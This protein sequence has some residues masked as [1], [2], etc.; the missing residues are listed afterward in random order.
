LPHW[1][2]NSPLLLT[3]LVI[4]AG[5][6]GAARPAPLPPGRVQFVEAGTAQGDI[7]GSGTIVWQNPAGRGVTLPV[8]AT[9]PVVIAATSA[10]SVTA[11]GA[12]AGARYWER[13]VGGSIAGPPT[14][15]GHRIYVG[16]RARDGSVYAIDPVSGRRIWSRRVGDVRGGVVF[17]DRLVLAGTAR[18]ELV[19]LD[20][21]AGVIRWRTQ[22]AGAVATTPVVRGTHAFVATETDTLY[23]VSLRGG[24]IELRVAIR[25][26]PS[27]P[28]AVQNDVLVLALHSREVAAYALPDLRERWRV[29]VDDVPLARPVWDDDAV[30]VATRTASIWRIEPETAPRRI[31]NPGGAITTTFMGAGG[32]IVLGR[33]DG[34]LI[35]FERDGREIW[36]VDLGSSIVA[37]A[38]VLD[39]ALFVGLLDGNV[40]R[41]R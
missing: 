25:A 17:A 30:V 14:S 7:P 32:R 15:D 10:R 22:L 20:D 26:T 37:P 40:V 9:G 18:G 19:A 24:T 6:L 11:L 2:V 27:A 5:C 28:P 33:L 23:R 36:R 3:A 41:I 4:G 1:I 29:T 12:E 13:K 21:S 34:T 35:C 16:T 39:G 8:L 31:A 38:T